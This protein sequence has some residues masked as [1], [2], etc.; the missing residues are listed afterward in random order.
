MFILRNRE[1]IDYI[2]NLVQPVYRIYANN[3]F[4]ARLRYEQYRNK[5]KIDVFLNK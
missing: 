2:E 3:N 1:V 5:A 4:F